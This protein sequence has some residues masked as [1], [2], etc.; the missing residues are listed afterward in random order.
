MA[1]SPGSDLPAGH[2]PITRTAGHAATSTPT[3]TPGVAASTDT[4]QRGRS[5]AG[6]DM[7]QDDRAAVPA[8]QGDGAVGSGLAENRGVGAG[9]GNAST[10]VGG[11]MGATG[12]PATLFPSQG[13]SITTWLD[14]IRIFTH[15]LFSSV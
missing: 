15:P 7:P 13:Q 14:L 10:L 11:V 1:R 2:A 9:V 3:P 4:L 12:T 8:V 6:S 5:G